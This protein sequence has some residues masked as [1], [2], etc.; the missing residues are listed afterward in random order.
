MGKSFFV[1]RLE[2]IFSSLKS[3]PKTKIKVGSSIAG[4]GRSSYKIQLVGHGLKEYD[5]VVPAASK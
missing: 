5:I 3:C 1:S 4:S 2:L